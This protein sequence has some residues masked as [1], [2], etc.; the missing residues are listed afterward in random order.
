MFDE[1]EVLKECRRA[2][3]VTVKD[4]SLRTG[5]NRKTISNIE[6][7]G[8]T[9]TVR[10]YVKLLDALGYDFDVFRKDVKEWK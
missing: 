5:V 3:G 8:V 7:C 2:R 6:N 1:G 4:L 9:T 10:T